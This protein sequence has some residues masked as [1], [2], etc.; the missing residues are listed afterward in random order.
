ME[1]KVTLY[2]YLKK[3][4]DVKNLI[5]V[6]NYLVPKVTSVNAEMSKIILGQN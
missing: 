4:I 5:E 2:R 3:S 1:E 6:L